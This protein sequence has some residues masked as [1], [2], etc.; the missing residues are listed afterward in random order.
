MRKGCKLCFLRNDS[1]AIGLNIDSMFVCDVVDIKTCFYCTFRLVFWMSIC[2]CTCFKI[3]CTFS[4]NHSSGTASIENQEAYMCPPHL[5]NELAI[6]STLY[7][8]PSLSQLLLKDHF[9]WL[10]SFLNLRKTGTFSTLL[11]SMWAFSI[12]SSDMPKLS[13][14]S[15]V[16]HVYTTSHT[17][18]ALPKVIDDISINPWCE[19][20]YKFFITLSLSVHRFM[21]LSAIE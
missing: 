1:T 11:R 2:V 17:I 21:R 12:S 20:K 16:Y 8:F 14:S 19:L 9:R 4:S 5:G 10:L 3:S 6:R 18:F 13:S 7:L 15:C